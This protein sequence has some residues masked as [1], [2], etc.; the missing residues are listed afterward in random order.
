MNNNPISFSDPEGDF[1]WLAVGI[2]AA[3][4]GVGGGINASN[5]GGS[6]LGGFA[7]GALI[8][9]ALGRRQKNS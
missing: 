5:N 3:L 4:Q 1:P 8:G 7:K 9:G 6:F 2:A